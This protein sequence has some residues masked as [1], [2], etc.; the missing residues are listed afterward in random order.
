MRSE[1]D[2]QITTK[3]MY[4]FLMYHAYKGTSG[5][6][7]IL[8]GIGMIAYYFYARGGEGTNT[9][10][11]LFF[12]VLFLVYQPWT[13]YSRAVKQAKLNPVFKQPLTYVLTEDGIEVRQGESANQIT[14]NQVYTVR[15]NG[16]SILLY[17][18][19]KNAFIWV[20]SQ[21]KDQES[22]V[23]EFL[24]KKVDAKKLKLKR[25]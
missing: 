12:G 8:I 5:L 1:F 18:S 20:K 19:N 22:Q 17:T 25:G 7:N 16:M 11:F 21:L 4:N 13:L 24:A 14:W 3:S 9:W 6:L 10:L 15:E 23:R 2:I